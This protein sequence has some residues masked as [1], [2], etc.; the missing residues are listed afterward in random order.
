MRE[1][2]RIRLTH[3]VEAAEEIAQFIAGQS[4]AALDSDRKLLFA[5][6]R[7]IEIL[8]EAAS[9]LSEE[10]RLGAPSVPWKSI[11]GMRNRVVHAYW[12]V[13][14]EIVWKT[15]TEEVPHILPMLRAL[16]N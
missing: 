14:P 1:D 6:V 7:A 9:R 4:R 15:A 12:D 13:D 5:V 11:V 8:G 3:M 2:D 10:T 16:L